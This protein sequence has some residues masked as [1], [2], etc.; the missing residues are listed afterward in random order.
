LASPRFLLRNSRY[1]ILAITVIAAV[2]T[3][4]P[5][6]FNMMLFAVPMVMLFFVGLFASYLLV[7]RREGKSFP[8]RTVVLVLL[9]VLLV[10][11][12]VV[13]LFVYRYHYHFIQK[14][15]YFTR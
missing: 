14:W 4:T 13:G 11:A 9:G 5:D 6:I 2:V 15:P 3:P 7:L 1:A 8:W 12:G 10:C